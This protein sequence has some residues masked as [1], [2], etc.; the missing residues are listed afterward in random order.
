VL[1][2]G[3]EINVI[4]MLQEAYASTIPIVEK[5]DIPK[6]LYVSEGTHDLCNRLGPLLADRARI[7]LEWTGIWT[8][9]EDDQ[10]LTAT[11]M[12]VPKGQRAAPTAIQLDGGMRSAAMREI[13]DLNQ[14]G[15]RK[16]IP[17]TWMHSHGDGGVGFSVEYMGDPAKGD[18]KNFENWRKA[19]AS[20]TRV[21]V[22]VPLQ[23]IQSNAVTTAEDGDIVISGH[24]VLD[25][26]LRLKLPSLREFQELSARYGVRIAKRKAEMA[27]FVRELIELL[28]I[29]CE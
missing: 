16:I 6:A 12:I 22:R 13:A 7:A 4:R 3:K 11:R 19:V 14:R 9:Y 5:P 17:T 20:S 25:A 26:A 23:L 10:K 28:N 2:M 24:D 18:V 21:G 1:E 15:K 27:D 29:T 8:A